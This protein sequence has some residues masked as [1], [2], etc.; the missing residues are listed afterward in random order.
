MKT[1]IWIVAGTIYTQK[2][3]AVRASIKQGAEM[4]TY[5]K[6]TKTGMLR[7]RKATLKAI[8]FAKLNAACNARS[9]ANPYDWHK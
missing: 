3:K 6:Y 9:E 2:E 8:E 1:I 4:F 7:K 5:K